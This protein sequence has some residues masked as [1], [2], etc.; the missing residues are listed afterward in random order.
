MISLVNF[1]GMSQERTMSLS[2]LRLQPFGL[3]AVS[4]EANLSI[5]LCSTGRIGLYMEFSHTM[6][7]M[8]HCRIRCSS[9]EVNLGGIIVFLK[10]LLLWKKSMKLSRYGEPV[11]RAM[12]TMTKVN[13]MHSFV[14]V[15]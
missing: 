8:T 6:G 2:H 7:A 3:R 11:H 10:L 9:R 12:E 5:V 13:S 15:T 4:V 14:M 1:S